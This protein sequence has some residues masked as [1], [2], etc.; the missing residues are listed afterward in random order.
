M[1]RKKRGTEEVR[2][3]RKERNIYSHA[4]L[5]IN[6][7]GSWTKMVVAVTEPHIC[8]AACQGRSSKPHFPR[9]DPKC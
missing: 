7:K 3:R 9:V 6:Q 4:A 8:P 1:G 2:R 5:E